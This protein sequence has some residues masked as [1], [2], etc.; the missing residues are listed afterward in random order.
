MKTRFESDD[1]LRSGKILNILSMVI[2]VK[3]V[4]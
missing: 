1:D 2:V 3:S 4:F